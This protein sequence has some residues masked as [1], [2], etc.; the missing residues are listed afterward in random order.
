[1]LI[2]STQASGICLYSNNTIIVLL[3]YRQISN[4]FVTTFSFSSY[5]K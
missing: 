4:L 1:M 2:K 3:L 5:C